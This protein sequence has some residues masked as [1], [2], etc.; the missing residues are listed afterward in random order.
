MQKNLPENFPHLP[1]IKQI[2][3]FHCGPAVVQMLLGYLGYDIGQEDIVEAGG[4]SLKR[5]HKIGMNVWELAVAVKNLAPDLQFW[6][7]DNTT[8]EELK[9]MV[10]KYPMA[11][12]WQGEFLE[13]DDDDNGHYSVVTHIANWDNLV[14]IADPYD[15]FAGKDRKIPLSRFEELWWD[16]NKIR[17]PKTD[18]INHV[19]DYHMMFT[20]TP[21]DEKLPREVGMV[22][23]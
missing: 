16:I 22:R 19:K 4:S 6:M 8:I 15:K 9:Q 20:I 11:V 18:R 13:Y 21:K 10:K 12:E 1:R 3:N 2:S 14:F 5:L 7:K 17:N 23:G